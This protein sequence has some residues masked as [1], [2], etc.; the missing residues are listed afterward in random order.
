MQT[1]GLNLSLQFALSPR[2]CCCLFCEFHR[3]CEVSSRSGS[4]RSLANKDNYVFFWETLP[5]H[6]SVMI[7]CLAPLLE[8]PICK[9]VRIN[10]FGF[11]FALVRRRWWHGCKY[12]NLQQMKDWEAIILLCFDQIQSKEAEHLNQSEFHR[13]AACREYCVQNHTLSELKYLNQSVYNQNNMLC[14]WLK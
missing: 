6:H 11:A 1:L 14:K 13:A 3:A 2:S 12:A 9:I 7:W 5:G 4:R 10:C 8:Q